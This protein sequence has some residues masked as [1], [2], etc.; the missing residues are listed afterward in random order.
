MKQSKYNIFKA[1]FRLF[2]I[3]ERLIAINILSIDLLT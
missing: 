1:T 2:A 3:F